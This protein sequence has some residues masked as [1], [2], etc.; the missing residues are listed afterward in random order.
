MKA[1]PF[2]SVP[3]DH[4]E[5]GTVKRAVPIHVMAVARVPEGAPC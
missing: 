3:N 5:R 1:L 2:E 4:G